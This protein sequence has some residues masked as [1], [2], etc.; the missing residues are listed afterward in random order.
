MGSLGFGVGKSRE[1]TSGAM[2]G[3]CM[4][5]RISICLFAISWNGRIDGPNERRY[6]Q[7]R[8]QRVIM[9]N[10]RVI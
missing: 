2:A 4:S 5:A 10:Q 7:V 9:S 1:K 6:A 8:G 3:L